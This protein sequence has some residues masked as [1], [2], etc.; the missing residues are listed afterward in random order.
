MMPFSRRELRG[1]RAIYIR[2]LLMQGIVEAIVIAFVH[3]PNPNLAAGMSVAI[4]TSFGLWVIWSGTILALRRRFE[5]QQWTA[6]YLIGG[7]FLVLVPVL[8][9]FVGI[10]L[11]AGF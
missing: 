9:L 5:I 2:C 4:L 3:T 1:I 6:Y 7:F 8:L 10:W 11:A